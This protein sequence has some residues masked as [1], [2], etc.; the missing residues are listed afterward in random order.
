MHNGSVVIDN[1]AIITSIN[2]STLSLIEA[3]LSH[4][5]NYTCVLDN[6]IG[7]EAEMATSFLVVGKLMDCS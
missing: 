3:T 1:A 5:G 2:E 4:S 6:G 7:I